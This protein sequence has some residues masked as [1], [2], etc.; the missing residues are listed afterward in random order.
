VILKH[1]PNLRWL[2]LDWSGWVS[3]RT[4]R[5]ERHDLEVIEG[6]LRQRVVKYE[7][8]TKVVNGLPALVSYLYCHG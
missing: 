7:L 1:A 3:R 5:D 2:E 4:E 6:L 8:K